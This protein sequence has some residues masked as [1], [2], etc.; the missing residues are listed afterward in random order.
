MRIKMSDVDTNGGHIIVFVFLLLMAGAFTCGALIYGNNDASK[1]GFAAI[2]SLYTNL[3]YAMKGTPA[4]PPV[5]P[6][7]PGQLPEGESK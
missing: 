3:L 7:N 1:W 5:E 6:S 2:A 4:K